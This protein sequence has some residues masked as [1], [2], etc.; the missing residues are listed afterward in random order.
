[1]F[2][3]RFLKVTLLQL[4]IFCQKRDAVES[5]KLYIDGAT[6]KADSYETFLGSLSLSEIFYNELMII[7]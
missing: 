6:N 4:T 1:M 3:E 7:S 2:S 5:K